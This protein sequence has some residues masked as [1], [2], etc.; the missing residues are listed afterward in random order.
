MNRAKNYFQD[1]FSRIKLNLDS[2]DIHQLEEIADLITTT[3]KAGN[4]V[5]TIGK[6]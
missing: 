4:K 5:I 2:V 1:Y 3:N 6:V